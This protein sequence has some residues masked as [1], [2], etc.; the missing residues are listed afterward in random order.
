MTRA[1]SQQTNTQI[2][3]DRDQLLA[4]AAVREARG[5]SIVLPNELWDAA[6]IEQAERL[7]EDPWRE[8]LAKVRGVATGD[9]V[10]VETHKLLKNVLGVDLER[11]HQGHAKRVAI[12]MRKLG[13]TPTKFRAG[14]GTVRGYE[15]PKPEGHR[16]DVD[17]LPPG[18]D[19][20]KF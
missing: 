7:E 12:Q 4:E 19:K 10:R 5:E 11:Q 17:G 14:S 6:A 13:W 8:V 18:Y 15:R 1:A 20:A 3:R 9:V 2:Q 16:D